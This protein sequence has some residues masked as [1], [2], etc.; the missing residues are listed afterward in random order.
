MNNETCYMQQAFPFILIPETL[1]PFFEGVGEG[2]FDFGQKS[3][4]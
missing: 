1:F 2:A 4:R 3:N